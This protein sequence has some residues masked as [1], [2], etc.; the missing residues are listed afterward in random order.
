MYAVQT[1]SLSRIFKAKGR[2]IVALK[3]V[4]LNIN[5]GEILGLL[6]ANGAG[7]TTFVKILAT[8]LLPSEG[9]AS[10]YG[11]DVTKQAKQIRKII[12]L[13]SGGE[14]PGYGILT[15]R[16]NLWF[17]S[18]L[19]G[20]SNKLAKER[21]QQ[22]IK[23]MELEEYVETRMHKLS[24]GFKQRLN[25]ARGFINDPKVLFL[26]EPTLGL[27]IINAKHIRNYVKDWVRS[28]KS[29]AVLLTTHYMA[30]AE[31]ICDKIAII[32]NGSIVA[33]ET[34]Q[35]L[36]ASMEKST[37]VRIEVKNNSSLSFEN[38][39]GIIGSSIDSN[40][41][42]ITKIKVVLDDESRIPLLVSHLADNGCKIM[43]INTSEPSLEDVYLKYV[44]RGISTDG[45]SK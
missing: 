31:E 44:G 30:E 29:R 17:F 25:L 40:S 13:V 20:L 26:D 15:V 43:S 24:T 9:K 27:D 2:P 45:Y 37:V 8:L 39:S 32:Y 38:V 16:E 35:T 33:C 11:F 12:N 42:G 18:Q 22:L 23:D 5:Y 41:N 19:Y 3:N 28:D 36:K 7:K 14:T 10:V 6:G 34:P 21:V 4:D 1:N